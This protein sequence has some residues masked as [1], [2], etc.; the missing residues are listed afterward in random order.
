MALQA[1]YVMASFFDH[2]GRG[3]VTVS[4]VQAEP[5]LSALLD[6]V[7]CGEEVVITRHGRDVARILSALCPKHPLQ[8]DDVAAFRATM[9]KLR[10]PS[11]ELLRETRDEGL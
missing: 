7:E 11:A 1:S 9:P 10:R 8:L 5:Q 3:M 6:R 4:L 2:P